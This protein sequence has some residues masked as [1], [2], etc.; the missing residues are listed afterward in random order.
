M[1]KILTIG[2]DPSICDIVIYDPTDVVSRSHATLRIDGRKYFI[3]DHSTNGTYR[4]GILLTPNVEYPVTPDDE[5]RFGY[6]A[7]LDWYNVPGAVKKACSWLYLLIGSLLAA[8]L[9]ASLLCF[10][11]N[12]KKPSA[13]EPVSVP[14]DTVRREPAPVKDTVVIDAKSAKPAVAPAAKVA[15]TIDKKDVSGFKDS[16]DVESNDAL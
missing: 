3:T 11:Q 5:V 12:R 16:D 13:E 7:N 15:K 6:S 9:V 2:R 1:K 10:V 4:N 8:L 14:V